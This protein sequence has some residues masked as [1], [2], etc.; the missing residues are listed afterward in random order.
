MK[1]TLRYPESTVFA[2]PLGLQTFAAGV[3]VRRAPRSTMIFGYFIGP[4]LNAIPTLEQILPLSL[5]KVVFQCRFGDLGLLE[6]HW[7]V[8]GRIHPWNR[9]D[10]PMP[11]FYRDEYVLL[12][13]PD[14]I[15]TRLFLI[16]RSDDNSAKVEWEQRV[17]ELP[18]P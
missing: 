13:P 9:E 14:S 11:L 18:S 4:T 1:A 2:V 3:V 17:N 7:P 5:T 16:K 15:A 12:R 8:V 6:G 10:W